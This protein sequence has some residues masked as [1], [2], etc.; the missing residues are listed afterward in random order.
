MKAALRSNHVQTFFKSSDLIPGVWDCMGIKKVIF[1]FAQCLLL[2]DGN[3]IE[4]SGK[5]MLEP[6]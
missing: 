6:G 2:T 5:E 4:A 3:R 1:T